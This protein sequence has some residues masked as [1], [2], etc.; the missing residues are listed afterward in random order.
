MRDS[1][2][3][4]NHFKTQPRHISNTAEKN[5]DNNKSHSVDHSPIEKKQQRYS[6]N[7]YTTKQKNNSKILK[8]R[9]SSTKKLEI[10]TNLG[11][12]EPLPSTERSREEPAIKSTHKP[13]II[14]KTST[15]PRDK[16]A[17]RLMT[18]ESNNS[19]QKILTGKISDKNDKHTDSYKEGKKLAERNLRDSFKDRFNNKIGL[20]VK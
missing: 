13:V 7:V 12:N 14:P 1:Q 4:T 5:D 11:D 16:Y 8:T 20:G 18:N 2:S 10:N 17:E 3:T 6:E 19:R 15:S 9:I